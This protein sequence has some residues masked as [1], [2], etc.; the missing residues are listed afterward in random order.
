[1][2]VEEALVEL[3]AKVAGEA[4]DFAASG[5]LSWCMAEIFF[6]HAGSLGREEENLKGSDYL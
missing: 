1:M 2:A 6:K 4:G 5:G 3:F